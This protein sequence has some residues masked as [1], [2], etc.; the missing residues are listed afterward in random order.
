MSIPKIIHFFWTGPAM[1]EWAER[2]IQEFRRLNPDHEIRIHGEE[3]ILPEYG[4]VA[5]RI[6]GAGREYI[7][8]QTAAPNLSDLGR[9][10]AIERFGGWYFDTDIF[11]FRPVAE[12]ERAWCLDGSKLFLARQQNKGTTYNHGGE[13]IRG[14]VAAAVLGIGTC[15]KSK[16]VMA[17][18]REMVCAT[19]CTHFGAYGPIACSD[20]VAERPDLV[21]V[22]SKEWF[23]GIGPNVA[24]D[25]YRQA[26]HG[27]LA[28]ARHYCT[29]GQMPYA[30]H[31]WAHGWSHKIDLSPPP[32]HHVALCGAA[33][34]TYG[35]PK[36]IAAKIEE[37]LTAAGYYVTRG[38]PPH[39]HMPNAVVV[40]NH[41]E[42]QAAAAIEY[43]RKIG[44]QTAILELGFLDRKDHVQVDS[45][46]FSHT[47]SWR[48]CVRT[49]PPLSAFFRLSLV[50]P[51]RQPVRHKRDGYVLV[52]GQ[53][54]GDKQLDES[55]I[56]GMPPLQRHVGRAIPDGT[57]VFFR[58]HPADRTQPHPLHENLP[59]LPTDS[60]EEYRESWKGKSLSGALQGAA[61]VI[62][63]NSTAINEALIAGVPVL[64]FGPHLSIEAGAAKQAT[65]ATL[66]DDIKEMMMGWT[67]DQRSVDNY[68]AWLAEKQVHVSAFEDPARTQAILGLAQ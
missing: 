68:L 67:P 6:R 36:E 62:T 11:P 57:P 24:S 64:A 31:L 29:G 16:V 38:Q 21:E 26:I 8:K 46:G 33:F 14:D 50:A 39:G 5:A 10:S 18:L 41:K 37:S 22:A 1:P 4:D 2:N 27:N 13:V 28:P 53:V 45:V 61:F 19:T 52:L 15:P 42:P 47:A 51:V 9:Y 58:P 30:M 63:I 54:T 35:K 20:L 65:V 34:E 43:A 59:R 40:W 12:I 7:G 66:A 60:F 25:I 23:F 49:R 56:R 48:S 44:A 55:E 3:V 32:I 17:T